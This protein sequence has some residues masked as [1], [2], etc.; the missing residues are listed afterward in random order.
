M[1][2]R[3]VSDRDEAARR[4]H[5]ASAFP[6]PAFLVPACLALAF[7]AAAVALPARAAEPEAAPRR[8]V[9][10]NMCADAL[11]LAL[12]DPAQIAALTVLSREPRNASRAA[13]AAL[14]PATRARAEDVLALA[15]DLVLAGTFTAPATVSML[16]RLGAPV[17]RLAVAHD[18]AA[19]RAVTRDVAAAV[20]RPARGEAAIA[21][22]DARLDELARAR[23][24]PPLS[25]LALQANNI[26]AGAGT[27]ADTVIAAAGLANAA[28]RA[29]I[30]GHGR[31]SIEAM[32]ALAPDVLI[33]DGDENAAPARAN[34]LMHHPA[35]A[36]LVERG[37]RAVVMPSRLW[38][39]GDPDIV[40][41][42][43]RLRGAL[44][45]GG[46]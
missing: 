38:V 3:S 28:A 27:L 20:G 10:I 7:L 37:T 43:A 21:A 2:K 41:A 14:F 16:R 45:S 32:L 12:A 11:L 42:V 4:R 25:A 35:L 6:V 9:S 31:M 15:P 1:T 46:A 29:G 44:R 36:A 22:M 30:A 24:V 8:I 40:E 26:V 19:I 23:P 34:R 13:Q 17:R 33:V 18:L 5:G 39:C